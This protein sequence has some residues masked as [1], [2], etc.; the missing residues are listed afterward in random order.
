MVK[1][2]NEDM[3][4]HGVCLACGEKTYLYACHGILLCLPCANNRQGAAA[5]VYKHEFVTSYHRELTRAKISDKMNLAVGIFS[6]RLR[7]CD[8]ANWIRCDYCLKRCCTHQA[9][10]DFAA[11]YTI[12]AECISITMRMHDECAAIFARM[13]AFYMHVDIDKYIRGIVACLFVTEIIS[14]F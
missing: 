14:T 9:T 8:R 12:C 1:G 3:Q 13:Y 11:T 7:I 10:Y 2:G 6:S 4:G 5:M